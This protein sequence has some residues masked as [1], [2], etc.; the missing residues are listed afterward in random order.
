M[1]LAIV[2]IAVCLIALGSAVGVLI[3]WLW[4][5][6]VGYINVFW[7]ILEAKL[8]IFAAVF[9][10]SAILLG[11]NGSVAYRHAKQPERL[12]SVI[13]RWEST[14]HPTSA[15]L[16]AHALQRSHGC[17]LLVGVTLALA[18]GAALGEVGNWDVTLRFFRQAPFGQPDPLYGE[19]IGFY[20]F[21]LPAFIALKNW[22]LLI[23][24]LSILFAGVIYWTQGGLAFDTPQ[25]AAPWVIAHG[26][27]LFGFL[28]LVEAWSY[29]IDRFLLLYDDN[30][31]VVGAGYTD[32]HVELPAL[33]ALAGL[34][35]VAAFV[36]WIN[37]W[38][39]SYKLL[40]GSVTLVVGAWLLLALA[41]P[42]RSSHVPGDPKV[43]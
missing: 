31:V 38:V 43:A 32:V 10:V 25:L 20:F 42:I 41:L 4:F 3:D 24:A 27:I 34:A 11:L 18:A 35:L 17:F 39:R 30:S 33:W 9:V 23:L 12:P 5:S 29:W 13:P 22:M 36:A 8:A 26:S 28:F 16:M 40:M 14:S 21:S 37:I 6:E 19:D 1:A 2:T 15:A 7:T